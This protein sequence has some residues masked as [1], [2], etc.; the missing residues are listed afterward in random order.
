MIGFKQYIKEN[1]EEIFHD[2][3]NHDISNAPHDVKIQQLHKQLSIHY[4]KPLRMDHNESLNKYF[5]SAGAEEINNKLW[6]HYK[7]KTNE[8]KNNIEKDPYIKPLDAHLDGHKTPSAFTVWSGS[9]HDPRD[10]M[11]K[12]G[13]VHHP[14]YLSTSLHPG[15]ARRF[16]NYSIDNYGVKN[17]NILKINIPKNHPGSYIG[18]ISYHDGEKEFLLPRGTN[19]RH[20]K[21]DYVKPAYHTPGYDK[22]M[23]YKVHTMEP[24]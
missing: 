1:H 11:N 13:I 17:P 9:R 6:S 15:V 16:S 4:G 3:Y 19:L 2:T 18:H 10:W 14:G 20:V 8:T 24:V 22:K 23:F 7:S 12:E 21:T 5:N